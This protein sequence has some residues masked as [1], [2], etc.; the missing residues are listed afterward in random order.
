MTELQL[1]NKVVSVAKSFLGYNEANAQDDIIIRKYNDIRA[2]GSYKM[3]MNDPWC[4]AFASVVG[5]IAGL[6]KIIP[7]ECSCEKMIEA[8]K[9]LGCWEEDGTMLP[10]IGDY[11]FYNWD[12]STQQND[13]WA[14]HVGIVTGVNG[15]TITVIEGNKNN[16]VE[17]RSIV[18]AWGYIR[19]Y[20]RPEYS[21]VADAE[22]TVTSDYGLGDLVQFSGNVHYES[23]CEGS[24]S[25]TC[26]SG[27]AQITAVSLGKAHPYH[28]VGVD[29]STVYGWVDEK[30]IVARASIKF[31][32]IRP[33][34]VVRVLNPVTYTGK[35]FDV[36][37]KSYDVIQVTGDRVVIGKG[38]TVTCAININNITNNLSSNA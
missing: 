29:G 33:G 21:K 19:G 5:Y 12:D 2:R 17:Y 14:D 37:Y 11:I 32:T 10:K 4:A 8:F 23:S 30:D 38:K 1:R 24:K 36:Y 13:G 6:R 28:L 26:T 7:V 20:G 22:T 15:R 3:S 9:K 31:G 25:H 35:K 27:K 34:D 16:A 18:I